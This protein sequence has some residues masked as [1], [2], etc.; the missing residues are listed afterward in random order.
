MHVLVSVL[1]ASKAEIL[2]MTGPAQT[3]AV[4]LFVLR[5][6]Q[7]QVPDLRDGDTSNQGRKTQIAQVDALSQHPAWTRITP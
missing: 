6:A 5:S 1:R 2:G 7:Q 4:W 3:L